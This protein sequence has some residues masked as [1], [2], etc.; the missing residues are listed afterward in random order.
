MTKDDI[1]KMGLRELKGLFLEFCGNQNWATSSC[2]R[3]C[4]VYNNE[5]ECIQW[6]ASVS[7]REMKEF[8]LGVIT[9]EEGSNDVYKEAGSN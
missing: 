2:W 7:E 3:S 8:L 1:N 9:K 6:L 5:C 4:P